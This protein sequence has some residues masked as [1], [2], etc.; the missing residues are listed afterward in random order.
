MKKCPMLIATHVYTL[1]DDKLGEYV[2]SNLVFTSK[3]TMPPTAHIVKGSFA[4]FQLKMNVLKRILHELEEDT[5]LGQQLNVQLLCTY[6]HEH[7]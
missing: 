5:P 6:L 4:T 2:F 1:R 7:I 3:F